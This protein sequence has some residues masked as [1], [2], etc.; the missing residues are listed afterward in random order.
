VT[1]SVRAQAEAMPGPAAL[2]R[3]NGELVFEAPWQ[4]RALGLAL[5]VVE[6]ARLPWAAFQQQLIAAIAAEPER[7][8]YESWVA[9]LEALVAEQ[10]LGSTA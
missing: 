2:P 8:Y 6:S 10:A 1:T 7:P 9:A 4:G 3:D 5:G